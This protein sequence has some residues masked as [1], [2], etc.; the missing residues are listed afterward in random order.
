[1]PCFLIT[2]L[3]LKQKIVVVFIC[4]SRITFYLCFH[5][6]LYLWWFILNDAQLEERFYC[7]KGADSLHLKRIFLNKT[8]NCYNVQLVKAFT[9][10]VN[11]DLPT[12]NRININLTQT[13]IWRLGRNIDVFM[14][15]HVYSNDNLHS[16]T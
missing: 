7:A 13:L 1:M 15:P 5:F 12:W 2:T 3:I 6:H 16:K 11:W 9:T 10:G 8:Q 4:K 14:K